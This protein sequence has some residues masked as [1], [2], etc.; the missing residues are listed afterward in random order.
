VVNG[1]GCC[2][3][4]L[5]LALVIGPGTLERARCIDTPC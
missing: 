5:L 3:L 2:C 1:S 4:G